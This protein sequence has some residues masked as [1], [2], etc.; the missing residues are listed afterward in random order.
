MNN[1]TDYLTPNQLALMISVSLSTLA[2]WRVEGNGPA[3]MKAGRAVLYS[4]EAVTTWLTKTQRQSTS[5]AV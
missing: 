3:F 4:H 2:R 1:A 5:E